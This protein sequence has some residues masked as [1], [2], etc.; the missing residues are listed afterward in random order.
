[1]LGIVIKEINSLE[2]HGPTRMG[3][4]ILCGSGTTL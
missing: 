3:G 4:T 1:M 2:Y